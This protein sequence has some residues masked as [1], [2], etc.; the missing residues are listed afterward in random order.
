MQTIPSM[1]NNAERKQVTE[2]LKY[3]TNHEQKAYGR[4]KNQQEQIQTDV[5]LLLSFIFEQKIL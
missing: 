5:S 4:S 2:K 1:R 3:F